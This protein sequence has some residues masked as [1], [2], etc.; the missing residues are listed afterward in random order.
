MR[1]NDARLLSPKAQEALRHRAVEAVRN[2]MSQ[3]ETAKVFSVSRSS[4]AKWIL[5]YRQGGKRALTVAKRGRRPV[6]KSRRVEQWLEEHKERINLFYLP[7]YSSELNPD[8]YLNNDV[9]SNAVG[10]R[11]PQNASELVG[12][13]RSYLRSTQRR[14]DIVKSYFQVK[15]VKFA[16]HYY[17]GH[18][19]VDMSC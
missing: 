1:D 2:G 9:K 11:R 8:E 15:Y 16:A 18:L 7:T 12:N 19:I 10:R 3:T 13:L 6:H 5:L 17:S 4:V 14:P